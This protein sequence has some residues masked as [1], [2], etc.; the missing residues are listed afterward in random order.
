M[1][2]TFLMVPEKTSF[3]KIVMLQPMVIEQDQNPEDP[4]TTLNF[5]LMKMI[6]I[7]AEA[8]GA[9]YLKQK[10]SRHALDRSTCLAL[11]AENAIQA[12]I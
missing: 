8:V 10:S 5:K 9:K 6:L 1:L 12:F 2:P 3:A 11:G 7:S 4:L